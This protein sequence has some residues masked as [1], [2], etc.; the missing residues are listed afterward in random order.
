LASLGALAARVGGARVAV[1]A[2]RVTVLGVL[3]MALTVAIG[4]AVGR[5]DH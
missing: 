5:L 3:A 4:A 2:L 1:G